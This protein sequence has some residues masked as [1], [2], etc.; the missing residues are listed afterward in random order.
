MIPWISNTA[1][2][3]P[4]STEIQCGKTVSKYLLDNDFSKYVKVVGYIF[5]VIS[6]KTMLYYANINQAMY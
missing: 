1:T 5:K 6:V 3:P 2:L 4:F